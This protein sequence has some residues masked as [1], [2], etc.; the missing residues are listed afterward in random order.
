MN[1]YFLFCSRRLITGTAIVWTTK[2]KKWAEYGHEAIL[3][4]R[5]TLCFA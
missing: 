3:V 4:W 5:L 2:T 1:E